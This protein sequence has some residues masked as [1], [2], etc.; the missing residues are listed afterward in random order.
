MTL[1]SM[2]EFL[3]W[4]SSAC[5]RPSLCSRRLDVVRRCFVVVDGGD[6]GKAAQ[7]D[8]GLLYLFRDHVINGVFSFLKCLCQ[9]HSLR[10]SPYATTPSPTSN[11]LVAELF[12]LRMTCSSIAFVAP[13]NSKAFHYAV[14]RPG[15]G[16]SV[17]RYT[18]KEG[19]ACPI[20]CIKITLRPMASYFLKHM[21]RP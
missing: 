1:A 8:H 2:L 3:G 14:P 20:C 15:C 16:N 21:Y 12:S 11:H 19:P 10:F 13:F 5:G 18:E 4:R 6:W 7:G 17:H 9:C